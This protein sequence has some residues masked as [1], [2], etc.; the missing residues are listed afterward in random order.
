MTITAGKCCKYI[1]KY[2]T[3][4]FKKNSLPYFMYCKNKPFLMNSKLVQKYKLDNVPKNVINR[5]VQDKR[6]L[7]ND[8][9][10]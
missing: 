3:N 9:I 1:R 6:R 4:G 5:Y 2:F 10:D 7:K 8:D